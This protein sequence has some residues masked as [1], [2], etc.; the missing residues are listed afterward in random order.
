MAQSRIV[1]ADGQPI[2]LSVLKEEL[3][4]GGMMSV[5]QVWQ[6]SIARGLTPARLAA[7]LERSN[8][9]DAD[10]YLTLAEEMEERDPHYA[11]VLGVRKRAIA[12]LPTVI[13][14]V[15]DSAEE[16]KIADALRELVERPPYGELIDDLLDALGKS[17]SV[18]EILWEPGKLWWPKEYPHRDP[19]WFRWD[20]ETG[21]KLLLR[22]AANPVDGVPMAPFKFV[23]HCPRLKT[24]LQI[25]SGLARLVAFSWICKA[26]ALK[27]WLAFAEVF[28]MPLRLGQYGPN[29]TADDVRVLKRA[30][31][32]IGSDAAAVIPE[33]M[34]IEF[35]E[36][37]S[38][39]GGDKL[40]QTL[41]DW[42]D[43][44]I[45]KA[46]LGQTMTTDA[47]S[48]GLG[49]NQASVHNE[50]REDILRADVRALETTLRRDL[51]KP[52]VDLNFGPRE[53]YPKLCLQI[54]QPEDL[55]L[56]S[57]A[58]PKMVD[59]GMEVEE[60]WARD[61]FGI[62]EPAKGAKLLGRKSVQ[63]PAAFDEGG[64][65]PALNARLALN[66]AQ[67][68]AGRDAVDQLVDDALGDWHEQM[69]EIVNPVE[70]LAAE[71]EDE[72]EFLRRLPELMQTVEPAKL[73]QA[74][75]VGA[76]KA[77]GLGDAT[78]KV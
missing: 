28:G 68:K 9:G 4:A 43:R 72:A 78:D 49:S 16:V 27:D 39:A 35:V 2:E 37:A 45:S 14:A 57:E 75:A 21:R 74:L 67:V 64:G 42:L 7:I 77:R 41:C 22:D 61:R 46:V 20:R 65:Q 18:C 47:Q 56:L 6:E 23:T 26:Y 13:E 1:G 70:Q 10:D 25:R 55:K 48:A 32:S 5:R 60:S 11:A 36:A 52:F 38:S 34:K 59:V 19:R 63:V 53:R 44:Q 33:S 73:L 29:A 40:Y 15:D 66:A 3:A 76:F 51:V 71:C 58:I 62:P 54:E 8:E 24:G 31:A 30:V 50:V 69:A 12:G 17:Y